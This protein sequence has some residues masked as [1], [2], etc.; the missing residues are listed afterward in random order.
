MTSLKRITPVNCNQLAAIKEI[1]DLSFSK[2]WTEQ[3]FAYFLAHANGVCLGGYE[4]DVLVSYF[5]GLLVQGD[6]DVI[7]IAVVSRARRQ[8]WAETLL[9]GVKSRVDVKQV[10]LEVDSENTSAIALYKKLNFLEYGK[11]KGYYQGIKDAVLM[12]WVK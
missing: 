11:R 8:G 7:S 12:K 2:R 10:F 1:A 9:G 4:G 5:L 6:L 3:D